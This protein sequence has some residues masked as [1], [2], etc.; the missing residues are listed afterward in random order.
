M[1]Y[2]NRHADLSISIQPHLQFSAHMHHHLELVLV[3]AG[4]SRAWVDAKEYTLEAGDAL[5]VF[6]NQVHEYF[7]IERGEHI[8]AIFAPE[9]IPTLTA[10]FEGYLPASAKITLG[11]AAPL[12]ATLGQ[13]AVEEHTGD[14]P[15]KK[16]MEIGYM[17]AM[18]GEIC[19]RLTFSRT[20]SVPS[21]NAKKVIDYCR[22]HYREDIS[23]EVLERELYINRYYIS[24]IFADYLHIGFNEYIN[25]LRV[26]EACPKQRHEPTGITEIAQQV[27]FG[28]LRTFNRAFKQKTGMT[29]S[30][31]RRRSGEDAVPMHHT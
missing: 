17:H 8:L 12:L 26:F 23:L 29:P 22:K 14:S 3:Q 6:P 30:E 16:T 15:Q 18:L 25:S 20:E 9:V 19:N 10:L 28:C 13:R 2:E 21:G 11:E 4:R 7:D 27:G 1:R 5:I 24:H 31:Y